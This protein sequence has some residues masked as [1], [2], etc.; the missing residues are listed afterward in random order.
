MKC[1]YDGVYIDSY[2]NHYA[3]FSNSGEKLAEYDTTKDAKEDIPEW[4]AEVKNE[5]V[6]GAAFIGLIGLSLLYDRIKSAKS[7]KEMNKAYNNPVGITEKELN[8]LIKEFN[9]LRADILSKQKSSNL[10]KTLYQ[11]SKEWNSNQYL[12]VVK[13]LKSGKTVSL[14]YDFEAR[15]WYAFVEFFNDTNSNFTKNLK[16]PNDWEESD[17]L[18]YKYE[19]MASKDLKKHITSLG[20]EPDNKNYMY[21]SKKYPNIALVMTD[22]DDGVGVIIRPSPEIFKGVYFKL[23]TESEAEKMKKLN[24]DHSEISND[25]EMEKLLALAGCTVEDLDTID[26]E[27]DIDLDDDDPIDANTSREIDAVMDESAADDYHKNHEERMKNLNKKIDELNNDR[28]K[29]N[30]VREKQ[31]KNAA[32]LRDLLGESTPDLDFIM[33]SIFMDIDH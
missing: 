25:P 31:D 19:Q 18:E 30:E 32:A 3:I 5:G 24:E 23:I 4:E 7:K 16:D 2:K 11:Y 1:Q 28:K 15:V 9:S 12:D 20:F 22:G 33:E 8:L 27:D 13:D 10:Y 6:V 26:D 14:E 21:Y 29:D 17:E